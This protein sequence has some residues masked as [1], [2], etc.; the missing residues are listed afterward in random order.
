MACSF[1]AYL[2]FKNIAYAEKSD[3]VFRVGVRSIEDAN[4]WLA[5]YERL[6]KTHW[7]VR[8]TYPDRSKLLY[9]K[10]YVCHHASFG[11]VLPRHDVQQVRHNKRGKSKNCGCPAALCIKI[12][13]ESSKE[14][15]SQVSRLAEV[16]L[17]LFGRLKSGMSGL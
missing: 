10:D 4:V 15:Y 11:R 16:L 17:T 13:L 7:I 8:K 14:H 2:P 9:R 5:E 6:S 12:Y 3:T 1:L